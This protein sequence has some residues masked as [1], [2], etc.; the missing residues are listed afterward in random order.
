MQKELEKNGLSLQILQEYEHGK[1][2]NEQEFEEV[3]KHVLFDS[4]EV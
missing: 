4:K 1:I 2:R 3:L